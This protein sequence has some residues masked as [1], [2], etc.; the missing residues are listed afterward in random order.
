MERAARKRETRAASEYRRDAQHSPRRLAFAAP[1]LLLRG[2]PRAGGVEGGAEGVEFVVEEV[3]VDLA[4]AVAV[5]GAGVVV[6][7]EEPGHELV[8]AVEHAVERPFGALRQGG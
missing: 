4:N 2:H 6:P 1:C 7:L 5:G 3:L 8:E